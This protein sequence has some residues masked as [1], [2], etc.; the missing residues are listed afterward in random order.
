MDRV[1]LVVAERLR[2][3]F[4]LTAIDGPGGS[5]KSTHAAELGERLGGLGRITVVHG[6]DFYRP[7]AAADRI[8]LSPADGYEKY[9]DWQRL[10][11]E[12]LIPLAAGTAA[13][14]RRYDWHTG[15]LAAGEV[16]HVPRSGV[17]IVEGVYTARPELEGYYDL[18]V[19]VDTPEEICRRRL[20]ERGGD[21]GPGN[22]NERW[23][24]AEEHYLETTQPGARLDL[25]VRG[26]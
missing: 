20:V 9:F 19:F 21:H 7:M 8:M 12:L 22:W 11:D 14:Y 10:R 25:T 5:G 24:A 18:T 6:D 13:R 1:A 16:L 4:M 17:V 3:G 15:A 26:Y 2:G 23:R